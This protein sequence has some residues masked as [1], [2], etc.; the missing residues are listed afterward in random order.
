MHVDEAD[1]TEKL[2]KLI[3]NNDHSAFSEFYNLLYPQIY[4]FIYRSTFDQILTEEICQETF[5]NF[6]E[7]RKNVS[8]EKYPKAYLFKI[9]KNLLINFFERTKKMYSLHNTEFRNSICAEKIN[10]N[11]LEYDLKKAILKLPERCRVIFILN[12]YHSFRYS[13]IAE[14]LDLSIQTV[15]NQMSKSIRILRKYLNN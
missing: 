12:R 1:I 7:A 8:T 2:V 3:R 4:N 13:E 9:A 10:E 15:K 14:I 11:M 6:W 5:I